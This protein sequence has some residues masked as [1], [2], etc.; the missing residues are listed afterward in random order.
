[1][2]LRE[3]W[4]PLALLEG[5]NLE[6]GD[7]T[8]DK[9]DSTKRSQ[10]VPILHKFITALNVAYGQSTGEPIWQNQ[11][12][13]S[14][15]HLAGSSFHFFNRPEITDEI[16]AGVKRT[17]GDIDLKV[18]SEKNKQIREWLESLPRGAKIGPARFVGWD[19]KDSEQALTLWQFPDIVITGKDNQEKPI[20]IQ[21]DLEMKDYEDGKPTDWAGFSTSSSWED[22]SEG[23]KGVFHKFLIQS[24]SVLTKQ[25]FVLQKYKKVR[26]KD[27]YL[28][29]TRQIVEDTM[30]SFAIK[31]KEGGGLRLKYEP[32][33]DSNTG[34][35]ETEDGLPVY[36]KRPTT[37]YQKDL[38][39]IFYQLFGGNLERKTIEQNKRNL[40]SFIGILNII[41]NVLSEDQQMRVARAFSEKLFDKGAQKLYKGDPEKDREE[42]TIAMRKLI[43]VLETKPEDLDQMI[44]DYYDAYKTESLAEDV[45]TSKRKGVVHLEK[46]KDLDFLEF[47]EEIQN[48]QGEGFDLANIK[49]TTKIDGLGGRFGKNSNG[50]PFFESSR[51]GPIKTPGAF[52]AHMEKQ[53]IDDPEKLARAEKYDNLFD[54]IM[55]LIDDIDRELGE[56]F[57]VNVKVHCE[58]LYVPMATETPQ[59]KLQYVS[60]EYDKLPDGV[61]LAV[62]P[63][64]VEQADTGED[65][66]KNDE[67]KQQLNKLGRLGKAQFIDNSILQQGS[68]D[69]TTILEPLENIEEL[70]SVVQS[71][72]RKG[73]EAERKQE[74]KKILDGMKQQ[75]AQEVIENPNIVGKYKLGDDYEGVILYTKKGPIKVT[76][77]KFKELMKQKQQ[78][79]GDKK[80]VVAYGN[81][82]GHKGH[83]LLVDATLKIAQQQNATPFVYI[84]PMVGPDDPVSPE[85][86]KAT[87]QKLYPEHKDAFRIVGSGP[88][89]EGVV[90]SGGIRGAIKFD[91]APEGFSDIIV[92]TGEDQKDA[93]KFLTTDRAQ[94]SMGVNSVQTV[95]RQDAAAS[96]KGVRS[97]ELRNILKDSDLSYEQKVQKWMTG[98]DG[99]KLGQEWIEK[100]MAEA[101]KNMNIKL[102]TTYKEKKMHKQ[103]REYIDHLDKIVGNRLDEIKK[104]DSMSNVFEEVDPRDIRRLQ[105]RHERG[106]IS[107]EEFRRELDN[108]AYTAQS[109]YE[110]EM[111]IYYSDDGYDTPAGHRAWDQE[112][113]EW[114]IEDEREKRDRDYEM[115]DLDDLL[116]DRYNEN[117]DDDMSNDFE[118]DELDIDSDDD[119]D[120][121]E[122]NKKTVQ[123]QL[124]KVADSDPD[125][126]NIKSP[127]TSVTTQ[128]GDTVEVNHDEAEKILQFLKAD[129][130]PETKRQFQQRLETAE[131]LSEILD[132]LREQ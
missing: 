67:I 41:K 50:E 22:L 38:V 61:D 120:D 10:V 5:G 59:G 49:M 45:A 32:V 82:M 94:K 109:E 42:K 4:Q 113:H 33:L 100:I 104:D 6:I 35:P 97:T 89:A 88:D 69:V 96:E 76:S 1:M 8:A 98:F 81:L 44:S 63:L 73:P 102:N 3:M 28:P 21:I 85:T 117:I 86:K 92:V 62:V 37:G 124:M 31:S 53:G 39:E 108:L 9:I 27:E 93:F 122:K 16:F 101:A 13:A 77:P 112:K 54:D 80:A 30:V 68:L 12:L 107:F 11:V 129:V 2:K 132:Y 20:N 57:L 58:I 48:K 15:Q 75:I 18:D 74:I 29:S 106:E 126:P 23:I 123:H 60:M 105:A 26:G 118:D 99:S 7:E 40:W 70:K 72:K 19:G 43:D 14:N 66:D 17:V 36:K 127:L 110:G 25:K 78:P 64:F 111:G 56:D 46:M 119:V 24:L 128:D 83:Q 87:F 121:E 114:D 125:D 115:R 130:S 91:L 71:R 131:G 47:V 34:E 79:K 95:T 116:D 52:T 55:D 84:S 90:R 65:H 51:S 103:I